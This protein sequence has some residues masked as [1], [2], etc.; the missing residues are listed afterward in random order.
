MNSFDVYKN[1]FI[2]SLESSLKSEDPYPIW[3]LDNVLPSNSI[4]ELLDIKT[5]RTDMEYVLGRREENNDKRGYFDVE[6]R[7]N[8]PACSAVADLFQDAGTI[9]AIE[10]KFSI[11]LTGTYL[12]IEFSQDSDGFWLEPHTDLGVKKFT[13]L[14][15]LSKDDEAHSWGSSIYRDKETFHHNTAYQSN[16][17]FIFIPSSDTWHG[18]EPRD[19]NGVRK[20]LIIN[21]V[22]DEWRARH[23]LA[24]PENPIVK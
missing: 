19:V 10:E 4:N 13:M 20:G 22:T 12:R 17:A 16:R 3:Q 21:Y 24:F 2:R 11:D 6:R 8:V 15:G 7:K 23:E 5:K 1:G 18:F 14:L 9:A